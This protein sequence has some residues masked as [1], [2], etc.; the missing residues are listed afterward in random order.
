MKRNLKKVFL[1]ILSIAFIFVLALLIRNRYTFGVWNPMSLPD[2]IECYDRRYYIAHSS[3]QVLNGDISPK[4]SI[5][6]SDN[7]TGKDLYTL[8]PKDK[9]VPTVIYL[10]T[11]D[12]KYQ[13]YVLSGGP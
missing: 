6:S 11:T 10:K 4:Y 2:R 12:G 5:S 8:E 3:P 9:L 7:Q 1:L 13:Q